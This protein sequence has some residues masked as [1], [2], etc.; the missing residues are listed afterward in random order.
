MSSVNINVGDSGY[1][2]KF[3]YPAGEIQV[4]LTEAGLKALSAGCTHVSVVA[5]LTTAQ[6]LMEVVLLSDAIHGHNKGKSSLILPYLPYSRADRRFVEGDCRG[7]DVFLFMLASGWFDEVSTLD[8]HSARAA[9][10]DVVNIEALPIINKAITDFSV[11]NKAANVTVL[12]PDKGAALRYNVPKTLGNNHHVITT[13]QAFCQKKRNS[14]TG[15][16]EGFT[17]PEV[18]PTNPLIIIDDICDGGGTFAGI[19]ELLP[20]TI[21][22]GLYV[23]HGIFSKGFEPISRFSNIYTTNSFREEFNTNLLRYGQSLK[24]YDAVAAIRKGLTE[25]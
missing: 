7:L 25:M 10:H 9:A 22:L 2:E 12:F 24:V 5:R 4:R 3:T 13:T 18:H 17:V 23:T 20:T 19:S 1:Y 21:P 14:V 16:F 8:V 15:K 6:D 11:V